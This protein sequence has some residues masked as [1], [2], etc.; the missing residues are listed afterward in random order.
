MR[1]EGLAHNLFNVLLL[2][3]LP[4]SLIG[5]LALPWTAR[6]KALRPVLLVSVLTFV[7]TSLV[8]PVATTWGTFLH[9]AG[10]VHVLLVVSCLLALD[11]G[12]ARLGLR[13]RLDPAG[14]LARAAA[15]RLRLPPLL[16]SRCC[17][18]SGRARAARPCSTTS[19]AGGWR[20]SAVRSTRS[21]GPVI[22]NFPIWLAEAD[23]I[24]SL[25]L[26][27]ET[28]TDVLDLAASFPARAC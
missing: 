18:R 19:S 28:P 20:P 6:P 3:G 22:A 21:A 17:R 5:L 15:R 23:R 11:A 2:T 27:D 14:R 1:V 9:A 4:I 7:V 13:L 24:P 16:A 10:P 12:I 8:F 25:A 26:P